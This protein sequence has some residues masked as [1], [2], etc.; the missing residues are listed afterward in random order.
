MP[1][2]MAAFHQRCLHPWQQRQRFRRQTGGGDGG[3]E[4]AGG[5]RREGEEA[6]EEGHAHKGW[7]PRDESENVSENSADFAKNGT[8]SDKNCSAAREKKPA[9]TV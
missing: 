8:D 1:P 7:W 2:Y 9:W 3:E 6:R 4:G 5:G